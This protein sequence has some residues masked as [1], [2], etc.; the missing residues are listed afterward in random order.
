MPGWFDLYDW[1]IAVGGKDDITGLT[2]AVGT[3]V[4]DAV[5]KLEKEGIERD[6]IVVG[7][8][9]QGG[10]VA[11]LS[12]YSRL[13]KGS[14]GSSPPFAGCVNLSGWVTMSSQL[15]K[16]GTPLFWGHGRFDD[17]VLFEQQAYGVKRLKEGLGEDVVSKSYDVAHGSIPTEIKDMAEFL[18][19]ILFANNDG[20]EL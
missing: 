12:A 15:E 10:A 9:S 19:R 8:F 7:G 3:V 1:P 5:E 17:K 11:L 20:K 16:T 4:N 2:D 6:R 18:D 14:E 13:G